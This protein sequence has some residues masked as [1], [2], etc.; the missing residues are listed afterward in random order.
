MTQRDVKPVKQ[1]PYIQDLNLFDRFLFRK[2]K[3]LLRNDE[4]G[5]MRKPLLLCS[6][7]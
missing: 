3:H 5:G 7:R 4:F 1:N 2:L 6:G